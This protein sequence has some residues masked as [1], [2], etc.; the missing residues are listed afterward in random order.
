VRFLHLLQPRPRIDAIL[1]PPDPFG[2]SGHGAPAAIG[3]LCAGPDEHYAAAIGDARVSA[4]C[5]GG[6][7]AGVTPIPAPLR[8]ARAAAHGVRAMLATSPSFDAVIAWGRSLRPA[9]S[10]TPGPWIEVDPRRAVMAPLSRDGEPT[11]AGVAPSWA[12]AARARD[13]QAPSAPGGSIGLLADE[14]TGSDAQE[15]IL[16]CSMLRFMDLPVQPVLPASAGKL[17]SAVQLIGP[18]EYTVG[19]TVTD[20]PAGAW[21]R[22]CVAAVL[23]PDEH[24]ST[25]GVGL[26]F[27]LATRAGVPVVLS[28]RAAA[29]LDATET[30]RIARADSDGARPLSRLIADLLSSREM[31][32]AAVAAQ[33]TLIAAQP[34]TFVASFGAAVRVLLSSADARTMAR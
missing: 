19:G 33:R 3:E 14:T 5:R 30:V 13:G 2:A 23:A 16:A 28:P 27:S 31:R 34:A 9:R 6:G 17:A 11:G 20:D 18:G 7:L 12:L 26:L 4:W 32:A 25:L 24:A 10:A 22:R 8:S 1:S 29:L 21:L 15:F